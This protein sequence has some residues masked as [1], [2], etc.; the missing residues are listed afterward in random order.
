[1]IH[2]PHQELNQLK[3]CPGAKPIKPC[4]S[5]D[6]MCV[7]SDPSS[8]S[9]LLPSFLLHHK[10][11]SGDTKANELGALL[12]VDES[13][14]CRTQPYSSCPSPTRP[15]LRTCRPAAVGSSAG[16]QIH[17]RPTAVIHQSSINH[18]SI[19]HQSSINQPSHWPAKLTAGRYEHL[20][21]PLRAAAAHTSVTH[22][23]PPLR[24]AAAHTEPAQQEM[25]HSVCCATPYC[26]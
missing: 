16:P 1:M 24:A 15:L 20:S 9:Q 11:A 7:T 13:N 2:R 23:S 6:Q 14:S 3:P 19:I 5:I 18:P 17:L 10:E 21:P 12:P 8:T 26:H 25:K 4:P 22:L